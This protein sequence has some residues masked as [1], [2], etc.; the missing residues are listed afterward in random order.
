[1]LQI[2]CPTCGAK[3]DSVISNC[4]YCGIEIAKVQELSPREYMKALT[5]SLH[6]AKVKMKAEMGSEYSE[7]ADGETVER[8]MLTAFP[9]PSDIP[10]LTEFFIFCHG[11]VQGGLAGIG[12]TSGA[13]RSKAKAAYDRLR[14]ASLNNPQLTSFLNDFKSTY[15]AEGMA[16]AAKTNYMF[17]GLAIGGFA[18]FILLIVIFMPPK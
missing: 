10:T 3:T 8:T 16:A 9:I 2:N 17:Y 14:L 11:N 6:E 18:L 5:R 7:M 1:M 12:Q 15:S 4:E 13:W